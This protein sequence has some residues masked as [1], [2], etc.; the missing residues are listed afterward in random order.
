MVAQNRDFDYETKAGGPSEFKET[1][2]AGNGIRY[3]QL[4]WNLKSRDGLPGLNV[5]FKTP[6]TS[7]VKERLQPIT[8]PPPLSKQGQREKVECKSWCEPA[9]AVTSTWA[10]ADYLK[11]AE[12]AKFIL[13]AFFFGLV[14]A[15]YLPPALKA[16]GS[17]L[18]GVRNPILGSTSPSPSPP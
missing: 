16:T 4:L 10:I 5:A 18:V 1:E 14:V 15:T 6:L 8:Q 11:K 7:L 12:E 13:L 17:D 3:Y 2:Y 9:G